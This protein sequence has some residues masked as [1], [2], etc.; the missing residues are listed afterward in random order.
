[1]VA[2]SDFFGSIEQHQ[3]ALLLIAFIVNNLPLPFDS[4][5]IMMITHFVASVV[6]KIIAEKSHGGIYKGDVASSTESQKTQH[7]QTL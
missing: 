6:G 4:V 2:M 5:T 3:K 1:M 7:M